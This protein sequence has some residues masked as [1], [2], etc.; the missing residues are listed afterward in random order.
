[1]CGIV[2]AVGPRAC[3]VV[4]RVGSLVDHRGTR[5][6]TLDGTG[7]AMHHARLP[8]VGTGEENDQP[9]HRGPWIVG[10]VGEI[11][12]FR[13]QPSPPECDAEL[14]A[15][16]W[17]A[18]GPSGFRQHDGFWH[19]AVIDR[20][21]RGMHLLCDYLAQKPLYVRFV[22]GAAVASSEIDPLAAAGPSRPD[23]LYLSDV[24]KWGYCPDTRRTPYEGIF[25]L[26]PGEYLTVSPDGIEDQRFP[27]RLEPVVSTP[28]DLGREIELAVRRRVLSADVP[29]ACLL[30]G[31]LDSSIV[32]EVARRYGN[33]RAYH[34]ENGEQEQ[35]ERVCGDATVLSPGVVDL[36]KALDY[37]QEP[38]DLGSLRP[39]VALSD[40]IAASGG[41]R[42]CL[43][44]DGA[45]EL[46]GG[47]ERAARYDSQESDVRRE[48]VNWHL[49]RLDRVMMRNRVEVRSPFL[50]RRVAALALGLPREQRTGKKILRDLFRDQLPSGTADAPKVPLRMKDVEVDRE[51]RSRELVEM[52]M[53]RF[54]R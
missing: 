26:E 22:G 19:L 5:S 21:R 3:D 14:A 42:V 53:K 7:W 51:A 2:A 31:G 46:F 47:Y 29:V 40:G 28:A 25:R 23:R 8:I 35:L 38:L 33:V 44:G 30:S 45:D 1:M 32:Y 12:D 6:R 36:G 52:F 15:N 39:Q 37:M 10:F 41:E 16:L 13:E 54:N 34:A 24:V 20:S 43:T 9:M 4:E 11:L 50:A 18:D 17:S 27:D 49:P 48:L